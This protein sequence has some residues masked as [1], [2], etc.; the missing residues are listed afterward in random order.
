MNF[1]SVSVA[2]DD[3]EIQ[4]MIADGQRHARRTLARAFG[5]LD[6]DTGDP[7]K[8]EAVGSHYFALLVGVASQWLTDPDSAPGAARIVA[9]DGG[10]AEQPALDRI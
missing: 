8:V 6:P 1:E 3:K 10:S 9:A 5:G 4:A 2:R 7:E